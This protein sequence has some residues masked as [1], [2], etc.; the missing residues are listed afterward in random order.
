MFRH[1]PRNPRTPLLDL[2]TVRE[3]LGYIHDDLKRTPGFEAASAHLRGAIAAIA[4]AERHRQVIPGN[5]L[6]AQFV[7]RPRN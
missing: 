3:T 6:T 2:E 1:P 7:R 4:A 5:I